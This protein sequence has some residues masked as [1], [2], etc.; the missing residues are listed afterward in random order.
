MKT[1]PNRVAVV[2]LVLL[3][4]VAAGA[5]LWRADPSAVDVSAPEAPAKLAGNG[6]DIAPAGRRDAAR[7]DA[8]MAR[9]E[10]IAAAPRVEHF[11]DI[12]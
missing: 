9:C 7:M 6:P 2:A 1:P 10:A 4:M 8:A 12:D 5:W 3:V 11:D